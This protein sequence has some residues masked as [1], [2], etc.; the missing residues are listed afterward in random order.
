MNGT[1]LSRTERDVLRFFEE[2]A[3]KTLT[4][5]DIVKGV[6]DYEYLGLTNLVDVQVHALRTKGVQI[7]TIRKIGYRYGKEEPQPEPSRAS[8]TQSG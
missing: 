5:T 6:W 3:G 8:S 1:K 7:E 4:R 2:N